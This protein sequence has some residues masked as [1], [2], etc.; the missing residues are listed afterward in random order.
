MDHLLLGFSNQMC[1]HAFAKRLWCSASSAGVAIW[2]SLSQQPAYCSDI[3][4]YLQFSFM[5]VVCC[6][7]RC[8]RLQTISF[9]D[10]LVLPISANRQTSEDCVW[11]VDKANEASKAKKADKAN[12]ASKAN[13]ANKLGIAAT[14]L[15][16][17]CRSHLLSN[18]NKLDCSIKVV[19]E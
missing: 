16:F 11:L 17:E 4:A 18:S 13:K 15:C 1:T 7:A 2:F 9:F 19:S 12:N 14:V 8:Y 6:G 3:S 10:I 5:R